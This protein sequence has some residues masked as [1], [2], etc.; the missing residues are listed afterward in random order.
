M[1]TKLN[2]NSQNSDTFS[3][4]LEKFE[5]NLEKQQQFLYE[6]S[7]SKYEERDPNENLAI[8]SKKDILKMKIVQ[9]V[10]NIM[11]LMF[12]NASFILFFN[13]LDG[14]Q[15]YSQYNQK[16]KPI[17]FIDALYFQ[18][19][20]MLTIGYGDITPERTSGRIITITFIL[21]SAIQFNSWFGDILNLLSQEEHT[22]ADHI[23]IDQNKIIIIGNVLEKEYQTEQFLKSFYDTNNFEKPC[24]F[25][26]QLIFY[27]NEDPSFKA[28]VFKQKYVGTKFRTYRSQRS[29]F[30]KAN[31]F[32]KTEYLRIQYGVKKIKIIPNVKMESDIE[33][34]IRDNSSINID[35]RT[36]IWNFYQSQKNKIKTVEFP[37]FVHGIELKMVSI[38]KGHDKI[39]IIN[40]IKYLIQPN[41]KAIIITN[42]QSNIQEEFTMILK[43]NI[44]NLTI[45]SRLK[46][47]LSLEV[48]EQIKKGS[49]KNIFIKFAAKFKNPQIFLKN[50]KVINLY[51]DQ[52]NTLS[53][54]PAKLMKNHLIF[55]GFDLRDRGRIYKKIREINKQRL[56][57]FFQH[58]IKSSQLKEPN[59][60]NQQEEIQ[61]NNSIIAIGNYEYL[62]H[63]QALKMQESYR[64]N[65]IPVGLVIKDK[66]KSRYNDQFQNKDFYQNSQFQGNPN[67]NLNQQ[68]EE[69]LIYE[70]NYQEKIDITQFQGDFVLAN[71]PLDQRVKEGDYIILICSLDFF[72][73]LQLKNNKLNKSVFR[74]Q[75]DEAEVFDL[76]KFDFITTMQKDYFE[77]QKE[78]T[79]KLVNYY[80]NKISVY[81]ELQGWQKNVNVIKTLGLE[82]IK[83]LK[84]E[85]SMPFALNLK[86]KNLFK[87]Q[88]S[89][90]FVSER[91]LY[92]ECNFPY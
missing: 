31:S 51:I 73:E 89:M 22:L 67:L 18:A 34:W 59:K 27:C 35:L 11:N 60:N 86:Q 75:K 32:L 54:I 78:I 28:D 58:N 14:K 63:Y 84:M 79:E 52:K 42:Y 66:I 44:Q 40:P 17:Y 9:L 53:Q 85:D 33:L 29:N 90:K 25:Q 55:V 19:V 26:K 46:R 50:N 24:K 91:K 10:M 8:S 37:D 88:S 92:S 13:E 57:I 48:L 72:Q 62:A 87:Q 80:R 69:D 21:I 20:T 68:N 3:Q 77:Q 81:K 71:P 4:F 12:L 45:K 1:Q 5:E 65:M 41:D 70:N 2:E 38:K 7:Y 82:E 16:E 15:V 39:L 64:Y 49:L 74:K 36:N 6:Q 23:K 83:Q 76:E 61:E 47:K 56:I 43:N 30:Q